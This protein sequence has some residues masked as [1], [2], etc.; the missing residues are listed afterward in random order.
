MPTNPAVLLK[1]SD[2]PYYRTHMGQDY[3]AVA[4][5]LGSQQAFVVSPILI[6]PCPSLD[7]VVSMDKAIQTLCTALQNNWF[8]APSTGIASSI[9]LHA[10]TATPDTTSPEADTQ[11]ETISE[12][13]KGL[14]V[15]D[16][17]EGATNYIEPCSTE[18]AEGSSMANVPEMLWDHLAPCAAKDASRA[19]DIRTTIIQRLGKT[20]GKRILSYCTTTVAKDS[21]GQKKRVLK[22]HGKLL[23]LKQSAKQHLYTMK[24][25]TSATE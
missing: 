13:I 17:P 7:A 19:A 2:G 20:E 10:M 15:K 22:V 11:E 4:E 24:R 25:P 18:D 16:Q 23:K 12:S 3:E 8:Q 6:C 5:L 9:L 14:E 1:R 21:D